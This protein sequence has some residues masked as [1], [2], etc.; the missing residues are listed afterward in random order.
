M[1]VDWQPPAEPPLPPP[2]FDRPRPKTRRPW[3]PAAIIGA[4]IVI[5]GGRVAGALMLHGGNDGSTCQAWADTRPTLRAIPALPAGWTWTTPNI[6][7]SIKNQNA[8]VGSAL[9]LFETKIAAK[10]ADVAQAAN[11][12]VAARRK[13][14]QSLSDHTY[15]A[16]DGTA[17][18]EA[19]KNLDQLCGT[20]P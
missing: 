13:Q 4:A 2:K 18:D 9:D 3:L 12:Y 20:S 6:D 14:M 10:P 1:N 15:T 16:S 17:V 11:D 19:L 7:T 5:A 8:P